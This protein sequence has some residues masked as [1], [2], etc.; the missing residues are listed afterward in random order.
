MTINYKHD[1]SGY[2]DKFYDKN[3]PWNFKIMKSLDKLGANFEVNIIQR[4]LKLRLNRENGFVVGFKG[5]L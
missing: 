3:I 1:E 4:V 5:Y 2:Q